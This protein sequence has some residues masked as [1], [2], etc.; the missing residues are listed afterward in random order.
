MHDQLHEYVGIIHIH[1]TYSDGSRP[2]PEIAHIASELALD[3]LMFTDHNTLQPKRDG[4]EGWYHGVLIATGY[5]I[6]DA[7]D[8]KDGKVVDPSGVLLAGS[9]NVPPGSTSGCSIASQDV[10]L[11]ERADWLILAGFVLMLM[12]YR[13]RLTRF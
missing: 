2:I 4:M 5:E 13:R 12:I 3:Y 10:K 1:S 11:K 8:L 7:D 9:P 6:N